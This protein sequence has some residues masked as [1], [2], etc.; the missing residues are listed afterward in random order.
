M[1]VKKNTGL[2]RIENV[3]H[4]FHT[5]TGVLPV[6]NDLTLS[7]PKNGFTAIV[8]PSGCGKSTVTRLVAGLLKPGAASTLVA[9]HAAL[10][11][12]W[13]WERPSEASEIFSR[14]ASPTSK[15]GALPEEAN[16]RHPKS[17]CK[18]TA[19]AA[20]ADAAAARLARTLVGA[21]IVRASRPAP[22]AGVLKAGGGGASLT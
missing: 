13:T 21:R 15:R 9:G 2:I 3:S 14:V 7:V 6:L 4:T 8:G 17:S 1:T 10:D 16:F 11:A 22:S 20:V 19:A 18:T 12:T 5:D